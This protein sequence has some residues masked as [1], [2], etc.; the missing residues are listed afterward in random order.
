MGEWER[1]GVGERGRGAVGESDREI[2]TFIRNN[3][4]Y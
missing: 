2:I 1:G 3:L 4:A